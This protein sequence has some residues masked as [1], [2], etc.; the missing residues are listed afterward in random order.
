MTTDESAV[1]PRLAALRRK[2][3]ARE[4]LPG[5]AENIEAIKRAIAALEAELKAEAEPKDAAG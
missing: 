4:N 1:D 2:L 3:K 5:Y